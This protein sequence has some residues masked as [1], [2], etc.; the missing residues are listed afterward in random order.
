MEINMRKY[1][2]LILFVSI[3]LGQESQE[4]DLLILKK[5]AKYEGEFLYAKS[6]KI[7]FK[8]NNVNNFSPRGLNDI[9]ELKH[10]GNV[11]I[12]NGKWIVEDDVFQFEQL[13][14]AKRKA[15]LEADCINN[16][17]VKVLLLPFVDDYYG[18]ADDAKSALE[19]GCYDIQSNI[20][21]LKYLGVNDIQLDA[22]NE[23]H[24][25]MIGKENNVDI[26]FFGYTYKMNVPYKNSPIVSQNPLN[27]LAAEADAVFD[28][29]GAGYF[30]RD[31]ATTWIY[32]QESSE[33]K[34]AI[35]SSGVYIVITYFSFDVNTGKKKYILKNSPIIKLG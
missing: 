11:I 4:T 1:I 13:E 34:N 6:G 10:N 9:K 21:A 7:H 22:V 28:M 17:S 3:G 27:N 23:Y 25:E 33:K 24:L 8:P 35:A 20:Q 2:F 29:W 18:L 30:F 32:G 16:K 15:K 31:I 19:T 26:V 5:G 14:L 12:K